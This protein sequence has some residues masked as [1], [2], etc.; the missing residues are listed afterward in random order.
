MK[1][2]RILA[3]ACAALVLPFT[4]AACGSSY[5]RAE[6]IDELVAQGVTQEQATCITDRV[7][8]EIGED[9]LNSRGSDLTAEEEAILTSATMDCLLG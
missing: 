6:F 7:E 9:R 8:D 4:A 5:D 1:T 3:T 2:T